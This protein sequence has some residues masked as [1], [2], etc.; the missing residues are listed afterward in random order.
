MQWA[1]FSGAFHGLD[2]PGTIY[3]DETTSKINQSTFLVSVSRSQRR[4]SRLPNE[5]PAREPGRGAVCCVPTDQCG[6][7][8]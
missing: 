2:M 7:F 5:M 3:Q 8:L 4:P 6:L 1:K